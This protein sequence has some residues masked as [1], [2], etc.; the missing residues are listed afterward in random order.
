MTKI[1]WLRENLEKWYGF[2]SIDSG[3]LYTY[4]VVLRGCVRFSRS[5]GAD[6]FGSSSEFLASWMCMDFS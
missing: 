2:L 6:I 1:R 4:S 3:S 5:A